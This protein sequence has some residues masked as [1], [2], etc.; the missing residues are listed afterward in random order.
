MVFTGSMQLRGAMALAGG[1]GC[2]ALLLV[3][4]TAAPGRVA[5]E[6]IEIPSP[7]EQGE[8]VFFFF[9]TLKPVE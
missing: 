5:L 9:I 3:A 4:L 2:V 7:S 1:M 6:T 8:Q